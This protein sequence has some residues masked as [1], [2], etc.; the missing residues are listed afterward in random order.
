MAE[1]PD[2]VGY[3]QQ[4]YDIKQMSHAA[5]CDSELCLTHINMYRNT[6][7]TGCK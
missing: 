7:S 5:E 6:L 1:Y 4:P 2:E 3:S